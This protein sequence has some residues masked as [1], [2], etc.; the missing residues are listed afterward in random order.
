MGRIAARSAGKP[1]A[2]NPWHG[3]FGLILAVLAIAGCGRSADEVASSS[4]SMEAAAD[5]QVDRSQPS[6]PGVAAYGDGAAGHSLDPAIDQRR[7]LLEQGRRQAQHLP[8][9][10]P[11]P[12]G[13]L[14]AE[15]NRSPVAG[16]VSVPG[17]LALDA[18]A[19]DA[20]A[21]DA[22]AETVDPMEAG[23]AVDLGALQTQGRDESRA[24]AVTGLSS[25]KEGG[26]NL[27]PRL[28]EFE[29]LRPP[30][31]PG[32][33]A[34]T[35]PWDGLRSEDRPRQLAEAFLSRREAVAGVATQPAEGYWSN[36]YIPGDPAMALLANQ[37]I[38]WSQRFGPEALTLAADR[39]PWQPFDPAPRAALALYLHADRTALEGEARVRLQVGI[40][41]TARASGRRPAT[42]AVVVF[43][44]RVAGLPVRRRLMALLQALGAARQPGDRFALVAVDPQSP[45]GVRT[46]AFADFRH[47]PLSLALEALFAPAAPNPAFGRE[48][49]LARAVTAAA[50]LVATAADPDQP[51]ARLLL[52]ATP[53]LAPADGDT[54]APRLQTLARR[55]LASSVVALG[56]GVGEGVARRLALA[57]QG[58]FRRLASV[59]AADALV[60]DELFAASR[61]VAQALRLRIHLA[62]GVELVEVLAAER[63]SQPQVQQVKAAEAELDRTLRERLGI[64]ADRGE[65]EAGIQIVIP[66]FVAGDSHVVLL[67]L[68][69]RRPGPVADVTLRYKD[70]LYARNGVAQGA[71]ALP[72]GQR[73][74]NPLAHQVLKNQLALTVSQRAQ[75]A[76]RWLA[77]GQPQRAARTLQDTAL[78]L[79]G[80]RGRLPGL[81]RDPELDDHIRR[82][83]RFAALV[84]PRVVD[85]QHRR[86]LA[87][88]LDYWAF[89][90]FGGGD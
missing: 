58:Q 49:A 1:R 65:D 83:E 31:V 46:V 50:R 45:D 78:L 14:S 34:A 5:L 12:S 51:G 40:Q 47:G 35:P 24:R 81:G 68:I 11:P 27:G 21:L 54:L 37:L 86:Y 79:R 22:V 32:P 85:P 8:P 39:P 16:D 15:E 43:D 17:A 55:G 7:E 13:V 20:L 64:A 9:A 89:R 29:D 74:P 76:G 82:L 72:A 4:P 87:G 52:L 88:A 59:D 80:L 71:L 61:T 30:P 62:T 77:A 2:D 33:S 69:A 19:L 66:R 57:G 44:P 63:L 70:L 75:G 73:P 3:G 28:G 53:H 90:Q 48:A 26:A 10:P 23:P 38:R 60:T 84:D 42:T 41:A 36:S 67:D 25:A 6:P 56:D 18:P